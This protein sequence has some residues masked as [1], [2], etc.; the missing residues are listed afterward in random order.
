MATNTQP[1]MLEPGCEAEALA[2]GYTRVFDVIAERIA[3]ALAK[4]AGCDVVLVKVKAYTYDPSLF[5][6]KVMK[7]EAPPKF[8]AGD[9]VIFTNVNGVPWRGLTVVGTEFWEKFEERRYYYEPSASPWYSVPESSL[10]LEHRG[11]HA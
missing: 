10:A 9:V 8:F 7:K 5:E 3:V 1:L 4:W 2:L 11:E 6:I